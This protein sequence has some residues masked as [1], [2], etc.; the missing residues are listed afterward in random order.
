M[1]EADSFSSSVY[2]FWDSA[3]QSSSITEL[4]SKLEN[5][6]YK[7]EE[8]TDFIE[9]CPSPCFWFLTSL[10]SEIKSYEKEL[11]SDNDK[12]DHF[13]MINRIDLLC[14]KYI[15]F[16]RDLTLMNYEKIFSYM[17]PHHK[18]KNERI[19]VMWY[20]TTLILK[21]NQRGCN[22][23]DYFFEKIKLLKEK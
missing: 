22:M 18:I 12:F 3:Y 9:G 1:D 13:H 19:L 23:Q 11:F 16:L 2:F 10:E 7:Q 6:N 4:V 17:L 21:H 8:N 5:Y 15:V 14:E 20:L